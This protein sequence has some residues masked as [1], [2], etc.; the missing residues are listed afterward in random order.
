MNRFRPSGGRNAAPARGQADRLQPCL[1]DRLTD[2]RP[3]H[4][5]EPPQPMSQRQMRQAVLRDL[6]YLLNTPNQ[7]ST[8]LMQAL[9]HVR[10]SCLNYGLSPLAG[11]T[12]SEVQWLDVEQ[13]LRTAILHFEPRILPDTLHVHCL[14]QGEQRDLHNVLSLRI[15]G[16]I[17]C[18]PY[19][20]EFLLRTRIDLESGHLDLE[21]SYASA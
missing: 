14:D 11:K 19:P 7:G 8:V 6:G 16:H 17:W 21:E 3:G 5:S 15:Q 9:T 10:R 13:A 2:E 4:V 1:L 18:E 12:M 20:Q